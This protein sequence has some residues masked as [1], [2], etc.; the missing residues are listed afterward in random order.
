MKWEIGEAWKNEIK[1]NKRLIE[2]HQIDASRLYH[3][4]AAQSYSFRKS[5]LRFLM[6]KFNVKYTHTRKYTNIFGEHCDL[7]PPTKKIEKLLT[8]YMRNEVRIKYIMASNV[9]YRRARI[10]TLFEL[11][12]NTSGN[13]FESID[14]NVSFWLLFAAFNVF[15]FVLWILRGT[16]SH[17]NVY[18]SKCIRKLTWL[19]DMDDVR[20]N[21]YASD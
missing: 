5:H 10:Y 12:E 17:R 3:S 13:I 6:E 2:S 9:A 21:R 1:N 8:L 15:C 16:C 4:A 20:N 19:R 14:R 18:S 7:L 11:I